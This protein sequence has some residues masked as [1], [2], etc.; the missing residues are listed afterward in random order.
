MR[1][2]QRVNR[3]KRK[4][5][6]KKLTRIGRQQSGQILI[7]T[8]RLE[9][10][11]VKVTNHTARVVAQ[12]VGS[13]IGLD[14]QPVSDMHVIVWS[15]MQRPVDKGPSLDIAAARARRTKHPRRVWPGDG[16]D[17]QGAVAVGDIPA[18]ARHGGR[19]TVIERIRAMRPMEILGPVPVGLVARVAALL[20]KC[21][22]IE[23][24]EVA[25]PGEKEARGVD[26][27]C[28]PY[29]RGLKVVEAGSSA[30]GQFRINLGRQSV[31]AFDSVDIFVTRSAAHITP[32][33]CE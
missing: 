7:G 8:R 23:L 21:R 17:L 20:A 11:V 19:G 25:V 26:L 16:Q 22:L 9:E 1:R 31:E 15:Q 18:V 32:F 12:A 33:V 30:G 28:Q 24:H 4:E 14:R 2:E 5:K 29:M 13:R 3:Q 27:G 6:K 10:R